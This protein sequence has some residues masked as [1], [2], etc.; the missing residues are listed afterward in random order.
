MTTIA[1]NQTSFISSA[2][3]APSVTFAARLAAL[4]AR[5]EQAA[6]LSSAAGIAARGV[7]AMV[8]FLTLAWIFV[9]V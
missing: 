1:F 2:E 6:G 9:A 7:L 5:Q 4:Q 3:R 8:P